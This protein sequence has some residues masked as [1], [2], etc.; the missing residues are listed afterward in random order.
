MAQHRDVA[1]VCWRSS[2]DNYAKFRSAFQTDRR[3][4]VTG[5]E[6][7]A[8]GV[9]QT[10]IVKVET[11]LKAGTT[12]EV[13]IDKLK[14]DATTGSEARPTLDQTANLLRITGGKAGFLNLVKR[15]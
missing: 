4:A 14:T 7:L 12:A 13:A 9:P 8:K 3:T 1:L 11:E 10:L 15:T 5:A 6:V 2:I